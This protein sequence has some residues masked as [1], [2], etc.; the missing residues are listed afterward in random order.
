MLANQ[1]A[2]ALYNASLYNR[3]Q[4]R[5]QDLTVVAELGRKITSILNLDEL[6]TQA[7]NL[8]GSRFSYYH[9]Q[10]FLTDPVTG[11]AHFRASTGQGLNEKWL[12]EDRSMVDE[13]IIGWVSKHGEPLMAND[14]SQEPRYIPDDPRLLPDTRAELAVPLRMEHEV[15]GVLDVQNTEVDTFDADDLFI[16]STLA[17]QVAVAVNA[18]RAYEAQQEEAWVTT[19]MLQV[20]EVTGVADGVDEVLDAAARVIAM[21]A[22]VESCSI[23]LWNDDLESF[24]YCRRLRPGRRNG[25]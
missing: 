10:I 16:L 4:R 25:P 13:G 8:I 6:L 21:L 24:D 22:G 5:V 23:W 12:R 14:V 2:A 19:V 20:A 18:A 11:R 3:N 9:A 1:S 15:L 7:I 17:D